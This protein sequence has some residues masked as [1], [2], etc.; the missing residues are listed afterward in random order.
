MKDTLGL[1]RQ[2]EA[3]KDKR[4]MVKTRRKMQNK[5][6]AR[7]WSTV[8]KETKNCQKFHAKTPNIASQ[9]QIEHIVLDRRS[10]IE[11][12]SLLCMRRKICT[13]QL[14]NSF[15]GTSGGCLWCA[16]ICFIFEVVMFMKIVT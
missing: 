4:H 5:N 14:S 3:T 11:Q 7:F 2:R 12:V 16:T 13:E 9:W 1:V 6:L 10:W 15:R 8:N